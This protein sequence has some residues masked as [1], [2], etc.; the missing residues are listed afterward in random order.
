MTQRSVQRG[1]RLGV[2]VLALWSASVSRRR[3]LRAPVSDGEPIVTEREPE[4]LLIVTER[5]PKM[6]LVCEPEGLCLQAATVSAREARALRDGQQPKQR[7]DDLKSATAEDGDIA[8]HLASATSP[9]SAD[10]SPLIRW[11]AAEPPTGQ[12]ASLGEVVCPLLPIALA[13]PS[14]SRREDPRP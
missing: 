3:C 2:C 4:A 14:T 10:A 12:R 5:E 9:R 7:A 13:T 11:R 1:R 6:A 8:S